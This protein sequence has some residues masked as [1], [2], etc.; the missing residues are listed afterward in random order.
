MTD[1]DSPAEQRVAR[2]LGELRETAP[3]PPAELPARV[4]RTARWQS[5]A[6]GVLVSATELAGALA[7][8][9]GMIAGVREDRRRA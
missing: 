8:G 5:A 6:R 3:P 4:V 2:L 7:T 1:P 9:L